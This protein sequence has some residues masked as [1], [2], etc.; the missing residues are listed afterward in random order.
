MDFGWTDDELAFRR[1]VTDF[2]D[3]NW[4]RRGIA[5]GVA[6]EEGSGP[7]STRDFGQIL[8]ANGWLT[9][10]WPEE[11]GG[12]AASYMA[13]MIFKEEATIRGAPTGG[14][15]AA[16][17]G[18]MMMIHGTEEQKREHLP[19]IANAEVV[20]CQGFSEP[21]SGSDLASLQTRAAREGDDFVI[22]GQKIWTSGAQNADFIHILTRTDPEAPKHRGISYFMLDMKTPGITVRP[23]VQM[24]GAAGFN[25]TFFEEVRVPAKNMFGE[26]NRGWYVA[27]TLLDFERSGV[28]RMATTQNAFD[29][30]LN[31]AKQPDSAGQGRRIADSDAHRHKLAET[32]IELA[33]CRYLSYHVTWMQSH[34][35]VPNHESSIAKVHSTEL[36]QRNAQRGIN[37]LGLSGVLKPE[38]ERAVM[39]GL[40]CQIYMQTTS[41]TIG[42]GTS[43][44]QRNI[45]ATRGLGLPRG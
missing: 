17:V 11:Y 5:G 14:M 27:T 29:P 32:A 20:W 22:N 44:I 2:L 31:H 23:L 39:G 34:G 28:D 36:L 4:D 18:P 37:M 24:H 12:Q 6:T 41:R 13:Q 33:V 7:D 26:E 30:L 3:E 42:G 38:S 8:A 40:Y 35:L 1:R 10:A 43:E 21:G 19:K 25:E 9:M 45:I 16:M 15:G